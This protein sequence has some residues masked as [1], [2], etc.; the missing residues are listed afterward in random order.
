MQNFSKVS[1]IGPL[2]RGIVF[3]FL[4]LASS[5]LKSKPQLELLLK[6][7]K[8]SYSLREPV[9]IQ[10]TVTNRA[11]KVFKSTFS[12]A[13]RYDF[14]VKKEGKETWRWSRDKVFAMMLTEFILQPQQS[15]IYQESWTPE[16]DE[17]GSVVPPGKY[18]IIGILKTQPEIISSSIFI[19]ITS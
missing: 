15:V 8:Q 11:N 13:Q 16:K 19:E 3:S 2:T 1:I 6:T 5:F 10:L 9:I 7:D 12:S 18:E 17:E 14:V 4:F